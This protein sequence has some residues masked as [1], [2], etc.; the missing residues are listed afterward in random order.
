MLESFLEFFLGIQFTNLAD[1]FLRLVMVYLI[2]PYAVFHG[3]ALILLQMRRDE[4]IPFAVWFHI[5]LCKAIL[6]LMSL[7]SIH[8]FFVI[9]NTSLGVFRWSEFPW[10]RD[11]CYLLLF[12]NLASFLLCI[13][14]YWLIQDRLKK[15]IR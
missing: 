15:I 7:L 3:L 1:F 10:S 9:R 12:P 11:N 6:I 13:I 5:Q 14:A 2:L 8:F 4:K